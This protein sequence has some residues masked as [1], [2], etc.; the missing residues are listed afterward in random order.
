MVA[1]IAMIVEVEGVGDDGGAVKVIEG[2]GDVDDEGDGDLNGE[3]STG[4][5]RRRRAG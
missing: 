2:A 4:G 1:V 5:G 3:G